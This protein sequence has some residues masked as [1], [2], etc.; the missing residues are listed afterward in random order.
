MI[1]GATPDASRRRWP[2]WAV[3]L[4][5]A[6]AV[7]SA[8]GDTPLLASPIGAAD[9]PAAPWQVIGLP[10]QRKPFTRFAVVAL[11]GQRVLR[12]EADASYG[13]LVHALADTP[14]A[15][16][17]HL[18]WRWRVDDTIEDAD[19]HRKSGDD[20]PIKVCALFDLPLEA[21]PF[22][23]RQVLRLARAAAGEAL[24]AASVCYVW[25]ARL[26]AG[27]TLDNVF[28]RRIRLVVLRGADA[29]LRTWFA[30]QR[31]IH[32]DFLRLF[33]DEA[34][35]VPPLLGIAVAA[36]ADNTRGHSLSY[37]SAVTLG[38]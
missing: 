20:S 6:A 12:I 27:T 34:K 32:A 2:T 1:A 17:R 28:S 29:P 25:D 18:A 5:A 37:L 21:V 30:E 36:D 33:G 11:D 26:A 35:T 22:V 10:K 13:N 15:A 19:L 14:L 7:A 23:E 4:A 24:P 3:G 9:T 16:A 31:D 38:P 8:C